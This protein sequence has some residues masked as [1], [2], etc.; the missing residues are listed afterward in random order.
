MTVQLIL[1]L[2]LLH[3]AKSL[4][5]NSQCICDILLSVAASKSQVKTALDPTDALRLSGGSKTS[6]LGKTTIYEKLI[7]IT[8]QIIP[9]YSYVSLTH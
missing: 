1:S 8:H 4:P 5:L 7:L 2:N 9:S 6:G 3:P